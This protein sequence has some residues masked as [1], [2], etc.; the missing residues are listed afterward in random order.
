MKYSFKIVHTYLIGCITTLSLFGMSPDGTNLL[1]Q[2]LEKKLRVLHGYD[3]ACPDNP[4]VLVTADAPYL[5]QVCY[6]CPKSEQESET[7]IKATCKKYAEK[8]LLFYVLPS[9][10]TRFNLINLLQKHGLKPYTLHAMTLDLTKEIPKPATPQCFTSFYEV[11]PKDATSHYKLIIDNET[12]AQGSLSMYDQWA[13]I[14][15]VFTFEKFRK[16]GCANALMFHLL[17]VAKNQGARLAV[18]ESTSEEPALKLYAKYAFQTQFHSYVYS[19]EAQKK[20]PSL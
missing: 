14:T 6:F 16:K 11:T 8:L 2:E 13:G 20:E 19:R 9:E 1:H 3:A 18:L 10:S 5:A 4:Q 15:S 17:N 12:A 7:L